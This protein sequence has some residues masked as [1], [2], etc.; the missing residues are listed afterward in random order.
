MISCFL[1]TLSSYG[2]LTKKKS[3][4]DKLYVFNEATTATGIIRARA[5]KWTN[6]SLE[7]TDRPLFPVKGFMSV[8]H[9]LVEHECLKLSSKRRYCSTRYLVVGGV[10]IQM[11]IFEW[12]RQIL[13][14]KDG[15]SIDLSTARR[16]DWSVVK[17]AK[18]LYL[19]CVSNC[20]C[21]IKAY[22]YL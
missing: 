4:S 20:F 19:F 10:A 15:I 3:L 13:P 5:R 17:G 21:V 7:A 2:V 9:L 1:D 11:F 16:L 22:L 14:N 6:L 8:N 12:W 18:L